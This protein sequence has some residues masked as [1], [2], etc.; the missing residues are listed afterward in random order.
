MYALKK[1]EKTYDW[2]IKL[3]LRL[4][5]GKLDKLTF[6]KILLRFFDRT[7][8]DFFLGGE[9]NKKATAYC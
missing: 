5:L 6:Q 9:K 7:F 8:Q 3:V 2:L 1:N 4:T